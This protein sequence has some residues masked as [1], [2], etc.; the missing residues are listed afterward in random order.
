MNDL[1]NVFKQ[2][3][4]GDIKNNYSNQKINMER[5]LQAE[6]YRSLKNQIEK[7]NSSYDIWLEPTLY[8]DNDCLIQRSRPDLLISTNF[9]IQCIVEIKYNPSGGIFFHDDIEKLR[10]F[11]EQAGNN[12]IHLIPNPNTGYWIKEKKFTI[13][14]NVLCVFAVIAQQ[15]QKHCIKI[16]GKI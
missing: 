13:S 9:E 12:Q 4:E 6:M 15:H 5:G 10:I 14:E 2:V 7:E 16:D 8:F 11:S 1:R 3:W